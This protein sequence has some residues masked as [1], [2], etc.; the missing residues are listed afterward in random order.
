MTEKNREPQTPSTR[1]SARYA[2][3]EGIGPNLLILA[4]ITTLFF[5]KIFLQPAQMLW[6]SDIVRNH[7]THKMVQWESFW[8]WGSFPLWDPTSYCGKAIVA[9]PISMLLNPVGAV[10]WL[11]RSPILFGF[12]GWSYAVLGAWGTFLFARKR[13]CTP[14]GAVFAAVAFALSGKIA[15]HLF[16]GHMEVLCTVMG[17]PW[18]LW[19][20]ELLFERPGWVSAV[21][22]AAILTLTALGGSVQFVYYHVLFVGV[23]AL[24]GVGQHAP[25]GGFGRKLR[26]YVFLGLGFAGFAIAGAAWWFPVVRQTLLLSARASGMDYSVTTM[27]SATYADLFRFMW[28]FNGVPLPQVLRP[29]P[30]NAFFW[31]ASSY[32]GVAAFCLAIAA[33]FILGGRRGI[34]GFAILGLVAIMLSLGNLSPVHWLACKAVPGFGLFRA[35]GR[36]LFYANFVIAVLGG[37]LLSQGPEIKRGWVVPLVLCVMLQAAFFIPLAGRE[38]LF[39]PATGAVIPLIILVILAPCSYLWLTRSLPD[40]VWRVLCVALLVGELFLFWQHHVKTVQ[41]RQATPPLSGA[42]FLAE[43]KEQEGEFRVLDTTGMIEQHVAAAYGFEIVKG[44]HPAI[45]GHHLDM[46]KR[47][48]RDDHSDFV[49]LEWHTP[50]DIACPNVLDL[51]NVRYLVT[52][53]R[54]IG[55]RFEHVYT[56]PSHEYNPPRL[57]YRRAT[58]LPR[59]FLVANAETPPEGMSVLEALGEIDPKV[60][61]LVEDS[62]IEGGAE[63]QELA[64]DRHSPS[65][66]TLQFKT[67]KPGVAVVSQSW[68][69]DWRA[70]DNGQAIEVRRV[71]H[72]QVGIP[73]TAGTHQLR[74]YYYPWDFY[75]GC[76]L[77]AV[78]WVVILGTGAVAR[79]RERNRNS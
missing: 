32:P 26:P 76:V 2:W 71:N 67:E 75:L 64:I 60:T 15:A 17:L 36:F 63:Y 20:V 69:P 23:Y 74:V 10:F 28:P 68:H 70:T 37:L 12:L 66:I 19:A 14:A 6:A 48:W 5:C 22:F 35:P 53:E 51:M 4:A 57:I 58:A 24:V 34:T 55:R 59:A 21:R 11:I 65:D 27:N 18:L 39:A 77:S 46:Y 43:Q 16:A 72:G 3:P 9:D 73:V 47:I 8:Q 54:P 62:P 1:K 52:T 61:C 7:Y 78:A 49:E 33:G 13:G 45:Y 30:V 38:P 31:E 44:Y 40:V 29:D 25:E 41:P 56:T 50:R 79:A 42:N